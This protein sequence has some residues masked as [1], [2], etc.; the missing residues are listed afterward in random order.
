MNS[1]SDQL[2]NAMV[3]VVF[4]GGLGRSGTTLL[5]RTLG[6]LPGACTLGEVVHLW[7]RG[8]V[9]D[10]RCGCGIRF[11]QCPFWERVGSHAFG[12]WHTVDLP[13]LRALAAAADRTRHLPWLAARRLARARQPAVTAYIDHYRKVYE[14]AADLSGSRVVIDSSKHASLAYCLRWR[15]TIDLRVVHMV[16]DSRG[17]A[18]S[19]TKR[20][21]RPETGGTAE[22]TRYTP[23]QTALLWNAHNVAF[24]MLE[25]LGVPVLRVH[26]EKFLADPVATTRTVARFAGLD[27][28]GSALDFLDTTH[29]DLGACHSVAGNPMRFLT[30]RVAL[31]R[32]D[33]WR[34]ALPQRDR[35]LVSA[36]TAPL[37]GVYGYLGRQ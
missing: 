8:I 18:H 10:D 22:M 11:S 19:W 37:L 30:G 3:R 14:A 13:R 24:T 6:E 5:E 15:D 1:D 29:A 23:A 33:D 4:L 7:Q 36:L 12:G 27:H 35:R 2:E 16:R 9:D 21:P 28:A 25:R 32:D 20:V 17:V 26:Y 34:A 31:R